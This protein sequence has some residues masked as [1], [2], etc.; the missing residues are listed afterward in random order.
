MPK[1][2]ARKGGRRAFQVSKR[3]GNDPYRGLEVIMPE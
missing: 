2:R 1:Q 3:D